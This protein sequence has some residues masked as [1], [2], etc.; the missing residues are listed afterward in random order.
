[1]DPTD[2]AQARKIELM[3]T[4]LT[5][6]IQRIVLD[7][8]GRAVGGAL[9]PG[10]REQAQIDISG[11]QAS[12]QEIA[13]ELGDRTDESGTADFFP[14]LS[15]KSSGPGGVN[16][17][18]S[19]CATP[20]RKFEL[21]G[22]VDAATWESIRAWM[23]GIFGRARGFWDEWR[24]VHGGAGAGTE[25]RFNAAISMLEFAPGSPECLGFRVVRVGS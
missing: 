5:L 6:A 4:R 9:T 21:A 13:D 1:M 10:Q 20:R 2:P 19:F 7:F 12:D 11:A 17:I 16:Q 8:A 14:S 23:N 3:R 25:L 24:R 18:V 15:M 22:E